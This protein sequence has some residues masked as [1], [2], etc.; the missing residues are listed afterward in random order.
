MV[1]SS[2]SVPSSPSIH[3]V[4]ESL[5][6]NTHRQ[7]IGSGHCNTTP[8]SAGTSNFTFD[9]LPTPCDLNIGN[10]TCCI[11]VLGIIL[12]FVIG[13]SQEAREEKEKT[14]EQ[15]KVLNQFIKVEMY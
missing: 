3:R 9:V 11:P 15:E 5:T 14:D 13:T 1:Q 7:Q 2:Q 12:C 10:V 4:T 6:S 8:A